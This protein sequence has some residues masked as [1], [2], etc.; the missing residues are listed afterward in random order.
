RS[1]ISGE[2]A[3]VTVGGFSGAA[4]YLTVSTHKSADNL[5]YLASYG[6]SWTAGNS[7]A[8]GGFTLANATDTFTVSAALANQA[9]NSA[10]GWNGASLTKA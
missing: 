5:Q 1:G 2:F 10:T 7:L 4:D 8:Q 6:L 3:N 9:A